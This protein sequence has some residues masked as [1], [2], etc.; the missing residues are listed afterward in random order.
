MN[1]KYQNLLGMMDKNI[2]TLMVMIVCIVWS[3]NEDK[4]SGTADHPASW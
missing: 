1:H 4:H 2:M 3:S